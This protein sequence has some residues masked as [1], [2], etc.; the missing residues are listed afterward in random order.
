MERWGTHGGA[1]GER[2][3]RRGTAHGVDFKFRL[4]QRR[5]HGGPERL[6]L[7]SRNVVRSLPDGLVCPV[8]S[9]RFPDLSISGP[10]VESSAKG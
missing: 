6:I 8:W 5:D 10:Q 4:C 3:D 1:M 2:Q 7:H 9:S